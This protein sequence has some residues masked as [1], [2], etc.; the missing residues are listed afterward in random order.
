MFSKLTDALTNGMPA[1]EVFLFMFSNMEGGGGLV[2]VVVDRE[3]RG[4]LL[5]NL[6]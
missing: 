1:F 2:V 5:K 3:L 6:T 4:G